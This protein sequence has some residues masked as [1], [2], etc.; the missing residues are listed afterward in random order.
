[1][2]VTHTEL[3]SLIAPYVLGALRAEEVA[4]VRSHMLSCEECMAEADG[5]SRDLGPLLL[6]VDPVAPPEG[7]ADR[8]LARVTDERSP[9]AVT[10]RRRWSLALG[11]AFL[12]LAVAAGGLTVGLVD[13]R[14]DAARNERVL[15]ALTRQG[16]LD[17]AGDS[18]LA[19]KMVPT[20]DGAAFVAAG[21]GEAP[22]DR[23]YQLWLI[24]GDRTVSV[25][26][27]EPSDGVAV[28][29]TS[30]SL[31][32]FDGAS[33]TIEPAGGSPQPTTQPVMSS[34]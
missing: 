22:D 10:P 20:E 18:G 29:E 8:V 7:F 21:L 6:T 23:T 25:S 14:R 27:F 11:T 17:L 12:A 16:G 24:K 3:K 1:M 28:V 9:A 33:V 4:V 19:G 5:Y 31:E 15:S 13:V 32:G 30:R 34:S 2:E 26:T